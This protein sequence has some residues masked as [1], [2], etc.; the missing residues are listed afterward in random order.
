MHHNDLGEE[1]SAAEAYDQS[2][3]VTLNAFSVQEALERAIDGGCDLDFS[4]RPKEE[5]DFDENVEALSFVPS[6]FCAGAQGFELTLVRRAFLYD[7]TSVDDAAYFV[8][9]CQGSLPLF[10]TPVFQD[11]PRMLQYR[12]SME[13]Q[14]ALDQG[15]PPSPSGPNDA[16]LYLACGRWMTNEYALGWSANARGIWT[17]E[18][19][20][21]PLHCKTL[22]AMCEAPSLEQSLERLGEIACNMASDPDLK[23][24]IDRQCVAVLQEGAAHHHNLWRQAQLD[25]RLPSVKAAPKP[26]F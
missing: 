22:I 26:R 20:G 7:G 12:A 2:I 5:A 10:E 14:E 3:L 16:D 17:W 24:L 11:E 1:P 8:A 6:G 25:S 23:Y 9:D 13:R 15:L 18:R 4:R 19:Q 21:S